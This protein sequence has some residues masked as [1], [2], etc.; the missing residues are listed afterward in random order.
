[1]ALKG[2]RKAQSRGSQGRR[3]PA[4]AP[5]A[6][7]GARSRQ[8]WY[9]S[10]V[11]RVI[12]ALVLVAALVA[13]IAVFQ[14]GADSGSLSERQN[15]L[16]GYTGDVR[17]LLQGITPAATDENSVPNKLSPPEAKALTRQSK[18]WR[19]QIATVQKTVGAVRPP[20]PAM[21]S[22]NIVFAESIQLYSQAATIYGLAPG[23]SARVQTKMLAAAASLRDQA[24]ALW[25]QG[26]NLLDQAR[27]AAKMP[28]SQLRI[29]TAGAIA[30]ASPS[31]G[32]SPSQ[33]NM[34][35]KGTPGSNSSK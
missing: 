15:A 14:S 8:P 7:Y 10:T 1:M 25:Q 17:A 28:P 6:A 12:A 26:V 11:A 16:D 32:A 23:T 29:P 13:V 18:S 4:Q 33:E 22:T 3:H 21:Q 24:T 20:T 34:N 31:P 27:I 9:R 2:K 19:S 30:P 5:R 35:D